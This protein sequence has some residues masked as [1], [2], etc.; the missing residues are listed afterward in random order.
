MIITPC[1]DTLES[2]IAA[3]SPPRSPGLHLSPIIKSLCH[4]IDP[5]RFPIPK[6]DAA[7]SD[8]P[9]ARFELGFTFERLLEMAFASRHTP[10][11][12]PGEIELDGITMSPDGIDPDGYWLEEYKVT[13]MTT[14]DIP[15][16][17]KCW[18]WLVQMKAYCHALGTV[19]GRLRVLC[20]NGWGDKNPVYLPFEIQFTEQELRDNWRMIVGEA[21]SKGWL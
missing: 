18:Q 7:T 13:W 16:G 19:N 10:I 21:R 6:P 1:A 3:A 11:F 8:M 9:W 12:R 4:G 14:A 15:E 5:K 20:V 2:M 17:G